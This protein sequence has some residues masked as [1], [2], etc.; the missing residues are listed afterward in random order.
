MK[1]SW[2]K[3][4]YFASICYLTLGVC[5]VESIVANRFWFCSLYHR[6]KE[7]KG[8]EGQSLQSL[9][10][11]LLI[12]EIFC[13]DACEIAASCVHEVTCTTIDNWMLCCDGILGRD[14]FEIGSITCSEDQ[15][16]SFRTLCWSYWKLLWP[17][18][19]Q[20][21]LFCNWK[22]KTKPYSFSNILYCPAKELW[23]NWNSSLYAYVS[24][25]LVKIQLN[26]TEA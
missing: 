13:V 17:D 22:K 12:E 10:K 4:I 19:L 15:L 20:N 8:K 1:V 7:G 26:Y 16:L 18:V 3:T 25:L 2:K 23:M 6:C 14:W 9:F 11:F 5:R 21:L 24:D